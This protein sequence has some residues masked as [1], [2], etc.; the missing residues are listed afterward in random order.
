MKKMLMLVVVLVL[1]NCNRTRQSSEQGLRIAF[2]PQLIGIPYF[3]AMK[4]GGEEAAKHFGNGEFLYVGSTQASSAEQNRLIENLI[5]Q[6]VDALSV[7][8]LDPSI[9]SV[10]EK[11]KSKGIKVYTADSDAPE[12]VRTVYVAQATDESL[13]RTLIQQL[14]SQIGDHGQI[15]IVSGESTAV[16][17]NSWIKYMKAE[18]TEN[19]PEIE[20]VDI[21]YT[22]GGSSEDA[23]RQSQELITRYPDLKGLVAVASTTVPGV[24]RAVEQM[25][26]IGKVAVI[27]YGSP[28]T[29]KPYIESGAMTVS[30]LWDPKAL[31]YLTYW[32]GMKLSL[33]EKF[34]EVN[35]VDGLE[36][37]VRYFKSKKMLLLGSP[38][39]ITSDNV[40]Q[41]DF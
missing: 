19:Y 32:A 5:T 21:R 4:Q 22:S 37:P 39:I 3:T 18:V 41:F 14:A 28:N 38:L 8:V 17:L 34:D 10:L 33:G 15:G 29:V 20:I 13:G 36:Q 35:I 7:S 9:N 31:G 6:Q 2:V 27:G 11:A 23:L 40:N 24:A 12:S 1:V 16:N 26:K 30:I 25:N